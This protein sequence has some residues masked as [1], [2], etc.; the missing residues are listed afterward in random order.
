MFWGLF[1]TKWMNFKSKKS[2]FQKI[3]LCLDNTLLHDYPKFHSTL[4]HVAKQISHCPHPYQ[5][6]Q[7][8]TIDNSKYDVFSAIARK[9]QI[10]SSSMVQSHG[11][12]H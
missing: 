8:A 9:R 5:L 12:G 3:Y 4:I 2:K 10:K 11:I 1:S 6:V 7:G